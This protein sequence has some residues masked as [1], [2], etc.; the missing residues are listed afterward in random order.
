MCT[1]GGITSTR[2]YTPKLLFP[3]ILLLAPLPYPFTAEILILRKPASPF[4][5]SIIPTHISTS[6]S[7]KVRSN[8]KRFNIPY[9]LLLSTTT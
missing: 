2:E 3:E 4:T 9:H 7:Q 1:V 5:I 8:K 6:P